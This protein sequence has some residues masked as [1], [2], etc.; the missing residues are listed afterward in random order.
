MEDDF[1]TVLDALNTS[2][3]D[4]D[5]AIEL[6]SELRDRTNFVFVDEVDSLLRAGLLDDAKHRLQL[7]ISPKYPSVAACEDEYRRAMG[8]NA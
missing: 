8:L 5:G 2:P 6:L 3:A 1:S 7:W 4:V